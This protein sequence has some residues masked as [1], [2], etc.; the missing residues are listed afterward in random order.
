MASGVNSTLAVQVVGT[1]EDDLGV[2]VP[3]TAI[4][5]YPTLDE[6]VEFLSAEL[7]GGT[8]VALTG[9]GSSVQTIPSVGPGARRGQR[10]VRYRGARGP[11]VVGTSAATADAV[12][13]RTASV[14]AASSLVDLHSMIASVCSV[15]ADALNEG[16]VDVDA[17]L[18]S[19][20]VNSTM[21]VQLVSNLEAI[22]GEELPGTLVFDYPTVREI[23]EFIAELGGGSA[24]ETAAALPAAAYA[25]SSGM[26]GSGTA[27]RRE[28]SMAAT[29]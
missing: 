3:G 1:L 20:G 15:V 19:M 12:P 2:A 25:A 24:P 18:M 9:T 11:G 23:A 13:G 29:S 10:Q 4:F 14:A 8:S 6:L 27:V 5:D 22:A 28:R 17:P 7:P 21:A 26:V 16:E